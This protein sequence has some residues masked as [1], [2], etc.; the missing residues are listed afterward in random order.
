M[1]ATLT[2]RFWLRDYSKMKKVVKPERGESFAHWLWRV[3][4]WMER[5]T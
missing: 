1:K 5:R 3:R 4:L 2:A